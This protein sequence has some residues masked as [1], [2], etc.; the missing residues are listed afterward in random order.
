[1]ENIMNFISKIKNLVIN[2]KKIV[3]TILAAII[4]IIALV[5]IISC[6]KGNDNKTICDTNNKKMAEQE[7]KWIYYIAIDNDEL[8]GINKVKTNGKKTE[9]IYEGKV[10]CL[11]LNGNYIFFIE[12]NN[13]EY[14]LVKIKNNG[15]KREV[16]AK[17]IDNEPIAVTNKYV[18]YFKNNKLH[19]MK[20]N[21]TDK[22]KM[23]D[24]SI[25][26][27]Q[28]VGNW[29]YYIYENEGAQYI[30]KMKLNGEKNQRISKIEIT[31]GQF[32]TLYV[33]GNKIYYIES[34]VN[35]NYDTSYYLYK[36]N[37]KGEKVKKICKLDA[38][39]KYICMQ[40]D[41]IYYSVSENYDTY[42]IYSIKYNGINKE[43]IKNADF[44][45]GLNI[46]EKWI[47]F[48]G[49][50]EEYDSQM[51]MISIDGKKEKQL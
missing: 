21:G 2:N 45:E 11:A 34:K 10:Q 20:V 50:N 9:K 15:K 24:K 46:T 41:K 5:V 40:E 14:N 4:L 43:N 12:E 38:E 25:S 26:Y 37:Q 36:M 17:G 3:Y 1:M 23:S 7:G 18:L 16:L 39:I 13:G 6:I 47:I 42:V 28:V 31:E 27:Y 48:S 49:L 22:E 51:K 19:K 44:F 33:K 35:N 30:A 8:S 29:I 32:E